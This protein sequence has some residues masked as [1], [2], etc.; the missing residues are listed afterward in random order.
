MDHDSL[1][2]NH[3]L[4]ELYRETVFGGDQEIFRQIRTTALK[5][6]FHLISC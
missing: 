1:Y 3:Y 5:R 6:D 4:P 2:V